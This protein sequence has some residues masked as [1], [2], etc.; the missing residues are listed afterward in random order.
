MVAKVGKA[1]FSG[2]GWFLALGII[3]IITGAMVIISP[4]TA[5][6]AI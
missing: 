4:L 5:T 2:W 3:L 6:L 1:L